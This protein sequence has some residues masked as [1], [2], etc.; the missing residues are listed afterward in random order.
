M[1]KRL[2]MIHYSPMKGEGYTPE[3]DREVKELPN[4]VE[5]VFPG[6]YRLTKGAT[7]LDVPETWVIDTG[8]G[9][10]VIDPGGELPIES[11]DEAKSLKP[12]AAALTNSMR[13]HKID[14]LRA[15]EK[16]LGKKVTAILLT[17]GDAD[18]TNNLENVADADVP[19]FVD[20]HEWWSTLSPEKQFAAGAMNYKKS[21]LTSHD[22]GGL[23]GRDKGW[24]KIASHLNNPRGGADA[25]GNKQRLAQRFRDFP[26]SFPLA[27]GSLEVVALPGHAPGEH[28]F[29]IPEQRLCIGGDLIST[30]KKGMAGRFNLFLPEANVYQAI[31]TARR[32]QEMDIAK[33]YPA[34]GEPI[35]GREVFREHCQR[36]IDDAD[37]LVMHILEQ[38]EQYPHAD[39]HELVKHVFTPE[40]DLPGLSIESKKTWVF[41]ALRN[42]SDDS[43]VAAN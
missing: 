30:S 35:I 34:H 20:R 26:E 19:I 18:H 17:H 37:R 9:L 43:H 16:Q 15:L 27:N 29:Y 25:H 40:F 11:A 22:A 1:D 31:A 23:G 33:Y 21:E 41:S 38:A 5:E 36:L 24:Q 3:Q 2:L 42:K 32:L 8:E 4:N 28:G 13:S 7:I 14:G 10:L 39:V 6:G 12:F